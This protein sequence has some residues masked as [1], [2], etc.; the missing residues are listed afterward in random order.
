MNNNECHS[1][2][3]NAISLSSPHDV[4]AK[5][6]ENIDWL[7]G[8]E[9]HAFEFLSACTRLP[10][11]GA[12]GIYVATIALVRSGQSFK[13]QYWMDEAINAYNQKH[14]NGFSTWHGSTP[15]YTAKRRYPVLNKAL[16]EASCVEGEWQYASHL[17]EILGCSR[18]ESSGLIPF[19]QAEPFD[20]SK[21]EMDVAVYPNFTRSALNGIVDGENQFGTFM[22]DDDWLYSQQEYLI[23]SA[24]LDDRCED[25]WRQYARHLKYL[26]KKGRLD[27]AL[28]LVRAK[29]PVIAH[30]EDRFSF[31]ILSMAIFSKLELIDEALSVLM[32][33]FHRGEY[34]E[35][36]TYFSALNMEPDLNDW[37]KNLW[38][39]PKFKTLGKDK[40]CNN[41]KQN[42]N[43]EISGPFRAI[44]EVILDGKKRKRCTVTRKLIS[45]GDS[46]YRYITWCGIEYI[47][48][49][50]AVESSEMYEWVRRH[51]ADAY[52]WRD[53]SH[54]HCGCGH[55]DHPDIKK[56][57]F[58]LLNGNAFN[59]KE[60]VE[61]VS[62]PVVYPMRFQWVS[63]VSFDKR[64][65]AESLYV[66]D[67]LAGEFVKLCWIA[68]KCG[69]AKEIFKQLAKEPQQIAD[70]IFAM[71]ATFERP[72]CRQAAAEH[73][74][75]PGLGDMMALA[76]NPR[77]TLDKLLQ[78]VDFGKQHPRLAQALATAMERYNLHLYS[79][80]RPQIDWYLQ[81]LENYSTGKCG[82]LL[83]F[84]IHIPEFVPVLK[85]MVERGLM[86]NG[87]SQGAYDGYDN[88]GNHFHHAAVIHCM[89]YAPQKLDHWLN[90]FWIEKFLLGAPLRQTKRHVAEWKKRQN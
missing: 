61:L 60:F 90:T 2:I 65:L 47:A 77:L 34:Y 41:N 79:N 68:I 51:C 81:G 37:L 15:E 63:D 4:A 55:F 69:H 5:L 32:N 70:P 28:I 73:F 24:V 49:K 3:S 35:E 33:L 25:T 72:D 89:L 46:V 56:Y 84:F 21:S 76:F 75:L 12:L 27:D 45:P 8:L 22:F 6:T 85:T 20:F 36:P 19:S 53:F 10:P 83:Y 44:N 57:L 78:L 50:E 13:A 43:D 62:N 29:L 18:D 42:K 82:Q 9:P 64:H 59:A 39:T 86:V 87:V 26:M 23:S 1:Y 16:F 31:H 17:L 54:A 58:N 74:D 48:G 71:L 40:P 88:T 30:L 7:L 11:I 38:Q 67:D 52:A 66:N 14:P 80:Y